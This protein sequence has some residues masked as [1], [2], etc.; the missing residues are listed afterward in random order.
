L[1][2]HSPVCHIHVSVSRQR[3]RSLFFVFPASSCSILPAS[4]HVC[5]LHDHPSALSLLMCLPILYPPETQ[6]C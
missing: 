3:L 2:H 4:L 1:R 5:F 6:I